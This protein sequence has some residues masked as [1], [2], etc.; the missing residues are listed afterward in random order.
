MRR[1]SA[2]LLLGACLSAQAAV[3]YKDS[4]FEVALGGDWIQNR[5]LFAEHVV[6]RS[7][8]YGVHVK[9]LGITEPVRPQRTRLVATKLLEETIRRELT[10]AKPGVTV[11]ITAQNVSDIE[12]GTSATYRGIDSSGRSFVTVLRVRPEKSVVLFFEAPTAF[13]QNL[14]R[15]MDDVL[16]GLSR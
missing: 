11:S 1:L 3:T 5:M 13:T 8:S 12:G 14:D 7:E 6:F 9:I 2:I 4:D 15:A 16:Q 10:S